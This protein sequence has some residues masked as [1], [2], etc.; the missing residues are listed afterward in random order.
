MKSLRCAVVPQGEDKVFEAEL[1][2]LHRQEIVADARNV[3]EGAVHKARNGSDEGERQ[4]GYLLF[5]FL[6]SEGAG[7]LFLIHLE[8]ILGPTNAVLVVENEA[9]GDSG[10]GVGTSI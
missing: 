3:G 2:M 8:E 10:L 6:G 5:A 9:E 1:R 7:F 4:T